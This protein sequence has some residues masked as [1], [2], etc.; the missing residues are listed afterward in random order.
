MRSIKNIF[1]MSSVRR[2]GNKAESSNFNLKGVFIPIPT[3]FKSDGNIDYKALKINFER[4]E[5][6]PF[7]GYCVGGSNGE[8]PYL[9][10]E[11]KLEMVSNVRKMIGKDRLLIVGTT[12]ESTKQT[13]ELS[14]AVAD[15]GADGVLVMSPFYFKT[16]MTE[17]SLYDHFTSVADTCPV[18][19]IVYNM[20]PVTGIDLSVKI[21][22]KMAM[23]PNIKGV[24]DKDMGK[25]AAI[26]NE[27]K[28]LD[29]EVVAGSASYLLAAMLVGCSGGINGLAAVL[30]EPLCEMHKLASEEQWKK[31]LILQRKLVNI[32]ILLMQE[33][34]PAG[35]KFAMDTL[36]YQGG[37]CRSPLPDISIELKHQIKS[38]LERSGFI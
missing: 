32:D 6:I 10:A 4:W 23:H 11:E 35:L 33:C 27:T 13:C 30:G 31:A 9:K 8:G 5:K 7:R 17:N 2:F 15:V 37:P 19:L 20:V 36:G 3:P 21:L 28:D 29:F 1:N 18:P 24:K 14:K 38:E 22:K 16:R 25:L 26:Y 12:C 34:G